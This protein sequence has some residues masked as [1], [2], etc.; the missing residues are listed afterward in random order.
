MK[1]I[2]L[3]QG[4]VAI[5]DDEDFERVARFKWRAHITRRRDGSLWAVYAQRNVRRADGKWT[6]EQM[7]RFILGVV[8][9]KIEID[10]RDHDGLN[11]T[12]SNLR[13]CT[14]A[15][16][17]RHS[18]RRYNANSSRFKGVCF[19]KRDKVWCA[20]IRVNCRR[21]FLGYFKTEIEA[22]RAYD[23]AARKYHGEFAL[24][25][26]PT[27]QTSLSVAAK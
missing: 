12:R 13:I 20:Q 24:L 23:R 10:H 11:N 6:T 21:F 16:N 27:E 1:E 5:V 9:P 22:A 2:P 25:N 3:T 17:T 4:Y 14:R 26:F 8:D 15:Q 7:H 18:R 19:Y